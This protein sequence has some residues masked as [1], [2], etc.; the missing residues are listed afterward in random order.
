[1]IVG[2]DLKLSEIR[3]KKKETEDAIERLI[4]SFINETGVKVSKVEI[5][6]PLYKFFSK[7]ER[8]NF[9]GRAKCTIQI[10]L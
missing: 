8:D 1:M 9:I 6:M 2:Q 3:R 4:A 10:T 5:D 7:E